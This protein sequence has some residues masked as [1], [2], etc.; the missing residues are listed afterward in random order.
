MS[1]RKRSSSSNGL[2]GA[3]LLLI[4][5]AYGALAKFWESLSTEY[6]WIFGGLAVLA[7]VFL[8]AFIVVLVIYKKKKR[9]EAWERA[10]Q[11]WGNGNRNGNSTSQ[12]S[13]AKNLSPYDLEKFAMQIYKKMGYVVRHTGHTGDHG[14]D[15]RLV[16]PQGKVELVQCKQWNKPVG[17]PE[18]RDLMGAM[19]HEK[20]I[21]GYIWAPGGFSNSARIWAKGKQIVLADE[22]E[23]S[24]LVE[25]AYSI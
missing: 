15:V 2:G 6:K 17:E 14:V 8:I 16:D 25:I 12:Q 20:A 10:M 22:K 7:L 13:S 5:M 24:Q 21:R 18:V 19:I 9:K 23:I 1:H 11:A 3:I 4:F